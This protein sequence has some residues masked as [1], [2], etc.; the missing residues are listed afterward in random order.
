MGVGGTMCSPE[1]ENG[2]LRERPLTENAGGA[3]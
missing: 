3:F 1:I 2:G